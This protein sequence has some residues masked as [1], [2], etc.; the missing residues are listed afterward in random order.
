MLIE[1][2]VE[3]YRSFRQRQTLS[4]VAAPR[5]G[6]KTNFFRPELEG[7]EAPALLKVAAIY[8]PNA[9]GKSNLVKAL[10]VVSRIAKL[11]PSAQFEKLPVTP[12]RFDSRLAQS[13]SRFELHFI[14]EK[15][16]YKFILAV[17]QER[18]VEE[19]LLAFPA[20]KETLYYSRHYNGEREEYTFGDKL[21]GEKEL[22][23]TWRKL[24]SSQR[25]FIA[26]AA[27]N[28][29]EDLRQL[30]VPFRWLTEELFAWS[31]MPMRSIAERMTKHAKLD[32]ISEIISSF[33][34]DLDIPVTKIQFER[35]PKRSSEHTESDIDGKAMLTHR[36]AIGEAQFELDEESL[37]T[38]NLIGFFFPWTAM[39]AE[40]QTAPAYR[41]LVVDEFDNSLHPQI[42]AKLV[43]KHLQLKIETQLIFTTHDTHLMDAK[44]LRRD[45]FWLTE[46]DADGA[47]QLRS[48]Y[49]FAGREGEDLEKRYYEGRYRGL[50]ILRED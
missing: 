40:E 29:S 20:G 12:F 48:V 39:N 7:E 41:V 36:S 6:R 31:D 19:Q 3:N 30:R 16:R 37:G 9:S 50:P 18:I 49:E 2:S 14:H 28:S 17:T 13:P 33:V 35:Q 27:A 26:Q 45:Q 44:L 24:T 5:L 21:E 15:Q 11:K 47:T 10:E 23:E 25:L 42:V 22:H 46:R 32:S 4:M 1:F 34:H 38:Q 8:G 43:K